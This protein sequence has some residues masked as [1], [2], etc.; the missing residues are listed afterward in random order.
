MTPTDITN[1]IGAVG[2]PIVA[3]CGLF[4]MVNTT[5]KELREAI[6]ELTMSLKMLR[7]GEGG[8]QHGN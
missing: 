4:W 1:A 7:E 2:F 6:N 5:M 8:E 3:C